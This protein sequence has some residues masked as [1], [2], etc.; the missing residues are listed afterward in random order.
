MGDGGGVPAAGG[1]F[2]VEVFAE[3]NA[4]H[5]GVVAELVGG[6]GAEDFALVDDVG[7]VGDGE[8]FADVVVGDEDADAA[9]FEIEDDLLQ[10][11]DLNGVDA[12]KGFVEEEEIG[13]DDEG[14]ADLDAAALAAREQRSLCYDG[15]F[16][17][18]IWAMRRFMRSC[19]SAPLIG[20]VCRM[21]MR[22]SST[23]SL[24]KTD[25]SWGR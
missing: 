21:A 10:L 8:R 22:L 13:V 14:A 19:R 4:A 3:V 7:A 24:R 17:G 9:V 23:D 16:R 11:Q 25:G 15:R 5:F 20:S 2:E 12:G 18:P 1:E 6:A